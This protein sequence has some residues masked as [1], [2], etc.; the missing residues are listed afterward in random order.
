MS[1]NNGGYGDQFQGQAQGDMNN[2]TPQPGD[3]GQPMGQPMD[4]SGNG[5][6]PQ[7]NMGPPGSAGGDGQGQGA[8]K[9]T[10]W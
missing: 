8:G 7:G 6:P 10:L 5:F 4:T 9:T 3:M 2:Q 1:F